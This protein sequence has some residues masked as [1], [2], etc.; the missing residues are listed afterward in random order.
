VSYL[1]LATSG[2]AAGRAQT[3]TSELRN[4]LKKIEDEKNVEGKT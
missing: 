2:D 1:E 4:K 3:E